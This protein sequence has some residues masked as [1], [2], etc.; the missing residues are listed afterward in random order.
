MAKIEYTNPVRHGL[1]WIVYYYCSGEND[2][3]QSNPFETREE[4]V[5]WATNDGANLKLADNHLTGEP[6]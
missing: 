4:A 2:A 5:E 3:R 1:Q 6:S